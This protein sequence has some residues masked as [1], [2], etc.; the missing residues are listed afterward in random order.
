MGLA[1]KKGPVFRVNKIGLAKG[2]MQGRGD[3][4]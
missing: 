1:L 3:L 2:K 4:Y